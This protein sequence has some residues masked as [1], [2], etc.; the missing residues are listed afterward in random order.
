MS[1]ISYWICQD[2][3]AG[4]FSQTGEQ[5]HVRVP[6]RDERHPQQELGECDGL[7]DLR[8]AVPLQRV[9]QDDHPERHQDRDLLLRQAQR[10]DQHRGQQEDDGHGGGRLQAVCAENEEN[11]NRF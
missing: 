10:Q 11:R 3:T 2:L 8:G 9:R 5:I 1:W 6:R 4:Y 7:L